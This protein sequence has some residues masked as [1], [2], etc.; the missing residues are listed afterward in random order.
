M[1]RLLRSAISR[2]RAAWL[3]MVEHLRATNPVDAIA[4]R[5]HVGGTAGVDAAAAA[6]AAGVHGVYVGAGQ[7]EAR[8]LRRR[9]VKRAPDA[10]TKKLAV[11]DAADPVALR[12]AETN[13]LDLVREITAEQRRLIRAALIAGAESG[14]NPRVIAREIR[15]SIGLTAYQRGI[16]ANYRA[17]LESGQLGKAL[18]YELAD[19]RYDRALR[20]AIDSGAAIPPDR[21]DAMVERY[22]ANWVKYRAEAIARTEGLRVAHQGSEEVY[23]QAIANGDLRADQIEGEWLHTPGKH[24]RPGHAKMHGQRRAYGEP[25]ETPDGAELRYP[26]DPDAPAD[27]TVCCKCALARHVTGGAGVAAE[28]GGPGLSGLD[29]DATFDESGLNAEDAE[30]AAEIATDEELDADAEGTPDESPGEAAGSEPFPAEEEADLEEAAELDR[31]RIGVNST[32]AGETER[33]ELDWLAEQRAAMDRAG[34][35]TSGMV[36][37]GS[38][39]AT[40]SAEAA[41]PAPPRDTIVASDMPAPPGYESIEYDGQLYY[42]HR[43]TG[44]SY[45]PEQLAERTRDQSWT[46]DLTG[47]NEQIPGFQTREVMSLRM[48]ERGELPEL[49]YRS[50]RTGHQY[51]AAQI[52]SGEAAELESFYIEE[53]AGPQ[54]RRRLLDRLRAL[55]GGST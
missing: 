54:P 47:P 43:I 35:T 21:I 52:A 25:F 8:W 51:T 15:E 49:R 11:F 33:D 29:D 10:V 6:F 37:P 26:C 20:A 12:W 17:A 50:R 27:E 36:S 38:P 48:A 19:G 34:G 44:R 13:R 18:G 22:R 16:V 55:L 7:A 32:I 46:F 45:T 23:R 53:E 42:R 4:A 40:E 14:E 28:D 31:F 5:L 30:S 41:E 9:L 3:A 1:Q 2:V 24:E 39:G